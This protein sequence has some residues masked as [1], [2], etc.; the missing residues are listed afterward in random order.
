MIGLQSFFLVEQ[1]EYACE[2]CHLAGNWEY[3]VEFNHN[4]TYFELI[5]VHSIIDC[6]SCHIGEIVD[7]IHDFEQVNTQCNEC[8]FDPHEFSFGNQC[9]RCHG[10]MDWLTVDYIEIHNNSF[11]PL[12]GGHRNVQC[13]A[14]HISNQNGIFNP[15]IHCYDCHN[16][17]FPPDG[18]PTNS[19]F[20]EMCHNPYR[21]EPTQDGL[22]DIRFPIYSGNHRGKWVDCKSCHINPNNFV[23]ISCGLNGGCHEHNEISMNSE[24]SGN[25]GYVYES[26]ACLSCHPTGSE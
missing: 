17:D 1:K 15:S 10:F 8:H 26:T 6:S 21:W 9:D 14:C 19:T 24:H 7:E 13:E 4:Q 11:F 12:I 16:I 23:E 18:H 2:L 25:S 5:G 22:H 20:C 3:S